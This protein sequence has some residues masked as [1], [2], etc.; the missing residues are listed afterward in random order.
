MS[1]VVRREVPV[2]RGDRGGGQLYTSLIRAGL[3]ALDLRV[4]TGNT[5][6]LGSTEVF[7][8]VADDIF[9]SFKAWTLE[10]GVVDGRLGSGS[11][12][13]IE[14]KRLGV[15]LQQMRPSRCVGPYIRDFSIRKP[16]SSSLTPL[17][18]LHWP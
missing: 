2:P 4:A 18:L 10:S 14:P 5:P 9:C 11:Q 7:L 8:L 16:W 17:E 15:T 12:D 6:E 13:H 1:V 3:L